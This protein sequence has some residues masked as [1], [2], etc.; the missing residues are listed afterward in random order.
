MVKEQW[1]PVTA[2]V[3]LWDTEISSAVSVLDDFLRRFGCHPKYL[4]HSSVL[5]KRA[6]YGGRKGRSAIRRLRLRGAR[7]CP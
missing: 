3:E 4:T 1:W 2:L 5:R 6:M 7:P